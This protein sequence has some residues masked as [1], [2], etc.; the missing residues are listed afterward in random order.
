MAVE[1]PQLSR[2]QKQKT[3]NEVILRNEVVQRVNKAKFLGV[4]VE[5][6]LN[7]EKNTFQ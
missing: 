2:K 5:E 6:H 1:Q 3:K 4:I 7:L